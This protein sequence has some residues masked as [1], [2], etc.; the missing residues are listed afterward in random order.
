MIYQ[1]GIASAIVFIRCQGPQ[2]TNACFQ[3]DAVEGWRTQC[4]NVTLR[5]FVHGVL[6]ESCCVDMSSQEW[7]GVDMRFSTLKTLRIKLD[8]LI[9]SHLYFGAHVFNHFL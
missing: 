7:R 4:F 6:R 1:I 8:P 3:P 5:R 9:F 2:N